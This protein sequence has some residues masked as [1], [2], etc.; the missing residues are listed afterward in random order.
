MITNT[1]VKQWTPLLHR[2]ARTCFPNGT[3]EDHE[4]MVQESWAGAVASYESFDCE[5]STFPTW[6]GKVAYNTMAKHM[7]SREPDSFPAWRTEGNT[8]TPE[9][10]MRLE[11]LL[12]AL[13]AIDDDPIM[14]A[15]VNDGLTHDEVAKAL[16]RSRVSITRYVGK[17]K[18]EIL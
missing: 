9:E 7:R 13:T 16:G 11:E 10:S 17:A 3:P 18:E 12:E 1:V 14:S 8:P 4:D 2:M 6:L 5:K 15:I